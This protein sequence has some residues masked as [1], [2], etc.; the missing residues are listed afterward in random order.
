MNV[1]CSICEQFCG[2]RGR[3]DGTH[4][5]GTPRCFTPVENK[6]GEYDPATGELFGNGPS[7]T[8]RSDAA[9]G[10]SS[11]Q[12][13]GRSLTRGLAAWQGL[14]AAGA[15]IPQLQLPKISA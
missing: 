5:D 3:C 8:R 2:T 14:F 15:Q 11:P 9:D 12:A 1:H 4:D 10:A 7:S 13:S 6:L